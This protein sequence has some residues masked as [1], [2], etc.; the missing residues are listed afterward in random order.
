MDPSP[1][2]VLLERTFKESTTVTLILYTSAAE[3]VDDP[4]SLLER[5]DVVWIWQLKVGHAPYHEFFVIETVD[6]ENNQVRVLIL[7]RVLLDGDCIEVSEV[8]YECLRI[9]LIILI[10]VFRPIP[11]LSR[12]PTTMSHPHP[13]FRFPLLNCRYQRPQVCPQST[14]LTISHSL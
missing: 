10:V 13:H 11:R 12:V 1:W 7:E 8:R 3:K 6:L 9:I 2:T 4:D 14:P 5:L